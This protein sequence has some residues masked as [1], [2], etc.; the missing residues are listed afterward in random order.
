MGAFRH[1]KIVSLGDSR[2]GALWCRVELGDAEFDGV[3]FPSMIGRLRPG[4]RVVVNTTGVDLGLGTGGVLFVLWNLDGVDDVDAGEGHIVKMRYTPWQTEVLSAEAPESPHHST[5]QDVTDIDG[6]PVVA[7]G[8]HS[9]LGAAAAG[10]R[11]I[12]PQ[13]RIGYL[14]TDGAALPLGFS[15]QVAALRSV[16][17]I[18][19]TCTS[20]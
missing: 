12:S 6:M 2:D 1:G 14:M 5:L 4:D 16:G 10:I 7:C 20:G 19:V 15:N 17:L 8:L 13:A 9:Q 18:D 3:A 11:A